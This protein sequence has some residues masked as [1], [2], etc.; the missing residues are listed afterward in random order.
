MNTIDPTKAAQVW[1]RVRAGDPQSPL[2]EDLGAL[3][4]GEW[5]SATTYLQLSRRLSG[6]PGAL[7]RKLS[8]GE[9]SHVACLKGIYTLLTGKRPGFTGVK[10]GTDD[11]QRTLRRCYGQQMQRLACYESHTDDPQYGHIFARVAQQ[12]R[13]HCHKLLE[14]LGLL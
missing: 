5:E 3:I 1:Q 6:H 13:E 7:L 10:P 14:I 8:E 9:Q 11:I 12:E 2:G 4:T